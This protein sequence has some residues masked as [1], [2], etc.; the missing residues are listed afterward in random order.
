MSEQINYTPKIND[1]LKTGIKYPLK[2]LLTASLAISSI[3]TA[4]ASELAPV[5]LAAEDNPKGTLDQ[6]AGQEIPNTDRNT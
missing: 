1:S 2:S 4:N 3:G 6:L 5:P